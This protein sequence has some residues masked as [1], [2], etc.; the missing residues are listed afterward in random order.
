MKIYYKHPIPTIFKETFFLFNPSL[1]LLN[2]PQRVKDT[3][4]EGWCLDFSYLLYIYIR[5][6]IIC[7]PLLKRKF[8]KK[9][10]IDTQNFFTMYTV[11]LSNKKQVT[12]IDKDIFRPT[13]LM[14]QTPP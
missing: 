8:K 2:P 14:T 5:N 1:I 9:S 7:C 3:R 12:T 13:K 4:Q 10:L 11:F 6:S